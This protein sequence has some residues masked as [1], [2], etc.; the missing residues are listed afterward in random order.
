[1]RLPGPPAEHRAATASEPQTALASATVAAVGRLSHVVID[2]SDADRLGLFWSEALGVEVA[3]R[4]NQYVMLTATAEGGPALA[5]QEVPEPKQG[6]NRVHVDLEVPDL[7]EA[8]ARVEA[9]GGSVIADH[10]QDGVH[11][12]VVADP[13][14]N[15]LCLVLKL[16]PLTRRRAI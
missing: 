16:A 4:W 14:G 7:D 6:K 13:E 5:F 10:E 1:V 12:R 11:I 3:A 2:C 9:L 8:S 15:E